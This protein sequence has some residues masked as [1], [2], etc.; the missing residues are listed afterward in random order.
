MH[1]VYQ[2]LTG[3]NPAVRFDSAL[4]GPVVESLHR[5]LPCAIDTGLSALKLTALGWSL[6]FT[7]TKAEA[8]VE[9]YHNS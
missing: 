6:A 8:F 4:T 1:P 5:A 9:P 3:R 2:A 7:A